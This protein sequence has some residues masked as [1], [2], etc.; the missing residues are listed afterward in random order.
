MNPTILPP[1]IGFLTLV[2]Q[3]AKKKENSEIKPIKVYFKK[4]TLCYILHMW[5]GWLITYV[6]F[7]F[8]SLMCDQI[9]WNLKFE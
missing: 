2:W 7:A 4:L 5:R 8:L 1:A 3:P 6:I 9:D